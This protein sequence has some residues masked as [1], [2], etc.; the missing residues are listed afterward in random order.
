MPETMNQPETPERP[1]MA[2]PSAGAYPEAPQFV[3]PEMPAATPMPMQLPQP[4]YVPAAPGYRPWGSA[5]PSGWGYPGYQSWGPWGNGPWGNSWNNSW[6]PFNSGW[7]NNWSPWGSGWGNGW[8][9][10]YGY[11]DGYG[12]T[13]GDGYGD[14][15][16]DLDFSFAM[17]GRANTDMRGYGYGDGYGSTRGYGYNAYGPYYPVMMRPVAPMEPSGPPD[18]D[19]DGIV[20]NADLCPD[21][22]EGVA[23]DALG[24][25]DAAR[26]VLRG[27]NFK[28]DS[29][30]LTAESLA[31]LDGVATT[32]SAN[33]QIKVM[34]AG[35]TDSDGEDAYNKDLSQRRAQSVVNYLSEN[36]VDRDSLIAKGY[37][38][39]QPV[40]GND[41][42]EGKA[43]NRRVELNR[44]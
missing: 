11:G 13:W 18:G 22:A 17:R 1:T 42:A 16:G 2:M 8:N 24:C 12:R 25:D 31:I 28:T 29:D 9:D 4:G 30:E 6:F 44:L 32:L 23:V 14:A 38:E 39:E 5:P 43:Q 15:A 21:T 33:P 37:G 34:V 10:G 36:G 20:D 26:I 7:G 27:V 19:N 35:H 3:A 40:A 41:T